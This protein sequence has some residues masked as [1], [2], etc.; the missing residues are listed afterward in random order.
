MLSG[1]SYGEIRAYLLPRGYREEVEVDQVN[2][3]FSSVMGRVKFT[4]HYGLRVRQAALLRDRRLS[5]CS[6]RTPAG[7]L[8]PLAKA[9]TSPSS[10]QQGSA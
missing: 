2:P 6:E 1:S 7:G 4:E 8:L 5:C 9:F 3:A 10:Y